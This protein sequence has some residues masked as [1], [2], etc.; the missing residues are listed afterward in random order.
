VH[1]LGYAWVDGRITSVRRSLSIAA[2]GLASLATLV[3]LF[4]YPLAMVGLDNAAVTNSN[5]PKVTLIALGAF[6]FGLAMAL[7]PAARRWLANIR[8]WTGVVAINASIMSLYLWHLTAMVGAI[9]ASYAFGGVGLRFS[10]NTPPWWATRPVFVLILVAA[11]VPFL[12]MFGRFERPKRDTR[13][14]PPTW[15]PIVATVAVCGGLGLLARYG[16]ADAEGLNGLALS[17]PFLG[18]IVGGVV[19]RSAHER[20]L[21]TAR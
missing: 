15:K 13:P 5:P 12:V 19:G 4:P 6:Q 11:T 1:F 16:V 8:P 7:A 14:T 9:G 10:V 3:A 2:G 20:S 21:S 18:V 17:L